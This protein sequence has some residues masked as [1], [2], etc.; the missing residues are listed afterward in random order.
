MERAEMPPGCLF[1][2]SRRAIVV[3]EDSLLS[4]DVG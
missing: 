2:R 1:G 4:G 3:N